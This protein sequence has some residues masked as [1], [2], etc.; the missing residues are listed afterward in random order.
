VIN[1][2]T[3]T[4]L[5]VIQIFWRTKKNRGSYSYW[6]QHWCSMAVVLTIAAGL[7]SLQFSKGWMIHIKRKKK[8]TSHTTT[9]EIR[10]W[11]LTTESGVQNRVISCEICDARNDNGTSLV[12][13][14]NQ[15]STILQ[16]S[17]DSLVDIAMD[18][19]LDG[20]CSIP[21]RGKRSFSAPK[22]SNWLL[23]PPSV[24]SDGYRGLF[25]RE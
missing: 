24:L 23:G 15:H 14:A 21:G 4:Q 18:C 8:T 2:V 3:A 7:Q 16:H 10:G 22:G 5:N 19:G 12:C 20:R 1:D 25:P 17:R 11:L 13:P 9:Q 6:S